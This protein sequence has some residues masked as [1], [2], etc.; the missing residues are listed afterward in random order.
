[1]STGEPAIIKAADYSRRAG[2]N[3]DVVDR[4]YT[5]NR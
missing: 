1:M 5:G 2:V 4:S 3:H